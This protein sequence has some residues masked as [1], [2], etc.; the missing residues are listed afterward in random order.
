MAKTDPKE[1][2]KD[3]ARE[4]LENIETNLLDLEASPDDD[5]IINNIFRALHTIKGSGSMF[6]YEH[7]AA[8]THEV[9]TLFDKIR[10]REVGASKEIINLTLASKDHIRSLLENE[11]EFA[12]PMDEDT[13]KQLLLRLKQYLH[14]ADESAAAAG[15]AQP[16][17]GAGRVAESGRHAACLGNR[18][19]RGARRAAVAAGRGPGSGA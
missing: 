15:P 10:E 19:A 8:F 13:E 2:Y 11:D 18:A 12:D 5:T 6:G 4:L 17:P 1:Y 16:E 3:E 9:E 7:I 14:K